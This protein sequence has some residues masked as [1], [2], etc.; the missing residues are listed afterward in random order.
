[1]LRS[2]IKV[3]I[4]GKVKRSKIIEITGVKG[5]DCTVKKLKGFAGRTVKGEDK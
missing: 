4:N 5:I 3:G 1:M 2:I